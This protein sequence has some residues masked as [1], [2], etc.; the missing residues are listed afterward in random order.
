MVKRSNFQKENG[1]NFDK[2][3]TEVINGIFSNVHSSLFTAFLMLFVSS[4]VKYALEKEP[5]FYI[6]GVSV[7]WSGSIEESEEDRDIKLAEMMK[8]KDSS[9]KE[10]TVQVILKFFHFWQT[11]TLYKDN[12]SKDES[13][14]WESYTE[15]QRKSIV[16][17]V[18][19][20]KLEKIK[21]EIESEKIK[22]ICGDSE[23][24][25]LYRK[26]FWS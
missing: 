23:R 12:L 9:Q 6:L 8:A 22:K 18:R 15:E 5:N 1:E 25:E 21:A 7:S 3:L 11:L 19:K 13:E 10:E 17:K 16:K 24:K 14:N 20:E 26:D 4:E 2:D